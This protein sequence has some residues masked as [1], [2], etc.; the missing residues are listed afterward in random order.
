MSGWKNGRCA[1]R[2]PALPRSPITSGGCHQHT[3]TR[4]R[5]SRDQFMFAVAA[6][7]GTAKSRVRRAALYP[8]GVGTRNRANR[9]AA[10]SI[11]PTRTARYWCGTRNGT[12]IDMAMTS[13]ADSMLNGWIPPSRNSRA[14]STIGT[15]APAPSASPSRRRPVS[16]NAPPASPVN[17]PATGLPA[18]LRAAR[19]TTSA[20]RSR[21]SSPSSITAHSASRPKAIPRAKVVRPLTRL[22]TRHT[23]PSTEPSSGRRTWPRT[24]R[25]ANATAPST[26]ATAPTPREP[27][28]AFSGPVSRLYPNGKIPPYHRKSTGRAP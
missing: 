1:A 2:L 28:R 18:V 10:E 24:S 3:S 5:A 19:A 13:L 12:A 8:I 17:R 7:T 4:A 26:D 9:P 6:M 16:S 15:A 23:A 11:A 22:Q 14:T 20:V 21:T 25:N 27:I